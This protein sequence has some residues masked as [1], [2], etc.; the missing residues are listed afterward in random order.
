MHEKL[1][2]TAVTGQIIKDDIAP[3]IF[4]FSGDIIH[5]IKYAHVVYNDK[6]ENTLLLHFCI[7]LLR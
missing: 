7:T 6:A 1:V 5:R 2:V 3:S 4:A